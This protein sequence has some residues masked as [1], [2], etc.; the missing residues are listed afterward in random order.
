MAWHFA[1]AEGVFKHFFRW[2]GEPWRRKPEDRRPLSRPA[3]H[4]AKQD[5]DDARI[6]GGIRTK[7]DGGSCVSPE[8]ASRTKKVRPR[9]SGGGD[10]WGGEYRQGP[11]G[12]GGASI[13]PACCMISNKMF[14]M[15]FQKERCFVRNAGYYT[16]STEGVK[17][18]K[19]KIFKNFPGDAGGG[20]RAERS[21]VGLRRFPSFQSVF[22]AGMAM[23][24][25]VRCIRRMSGP[26]T[27]KEY[28][29]VPKTVF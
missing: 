19:K 15:V 6:G 22:S 23:T 5:K 3:S 4:G 11:R 1:R 2:N 12:G 14:K 26:E 16:R 24:E 28:R 25:S 20:K 27:G 8:R 18:E 7:A 29:Y 21:A 13:L 9:L 17:R 10:T